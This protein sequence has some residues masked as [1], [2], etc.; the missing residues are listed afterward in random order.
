MNL[1]RDT[2]YGGEWAGFYIGEHD[3]EPIWVFRIPRDS[4]PKIN[5]FQVSPEFFVES[6]EFMV[7]VI[8]KNRHAL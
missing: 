7:G 6:T 3:F 1:P 2:L 8:T 5:F 4:C